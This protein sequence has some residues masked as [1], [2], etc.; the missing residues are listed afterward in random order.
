[1]IAPKQAAGPFAS[2]SNGYHTIMMI[3]DGSK[4]GWPEDMVQQVDGILE[5]RNYSANQDLLDAISPTNESGDQ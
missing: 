1:M 3:P 5:R 2:P 4:E